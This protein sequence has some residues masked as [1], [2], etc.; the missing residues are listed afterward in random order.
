VSL[1]GSLLPFP[2]TRR[3]RE[4]SDDP[5]PSIEERYGTLDNY[6]GQLELK[7]RQL[8]DARFLLPE[9]VEP[10]LEVQRERVAPLFME[11][12]TSERN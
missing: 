5:R 12:P 9:D 10:T 7:A 2:V 6:L 1:V 4:V 11:V 8:Q 3:Q